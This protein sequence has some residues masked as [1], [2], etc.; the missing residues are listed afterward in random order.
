MKPTLFI[1]VPRV[2]DRIYAG[3]LAKVKAGGAIKK[4]L[5]DYAYKH[6]LYYLNQGYPH[7]KVCLMLVGVQLQ[8]YVPSLAYDSHSHDKVCLMSTEVP[9]YLHV[10]C[11]LYDGHSL[12]KVCLMWVG[13][14]LEWYAV[15][16]S[17]WS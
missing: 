17:S 5:F 6:K 9:P 4:W 1:G 3:V 11:P 12:N 10:P 16:P 15:S 8:L 13:V 14:Q 7:D 2:F